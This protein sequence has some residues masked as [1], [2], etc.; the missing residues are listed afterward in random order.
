M[1][2]APGAPHVAQGE[3]R[4]SQCITLKLWTVHRKYSFQHSM[5]KKEGY[6]NQFYEMIPSHRR[7][8]NRPANKLTLM[9]HYVIL[10]FYPE[11]VLVPSHWIKLDLCDKSIPAERLRGKMATTYIAMFSALSKKLQLAIPHSVMIVVGTLP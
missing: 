1:L 4:T 2:I 7:L 11:L 3:W 5:M 10:G 9:S 8:R 6:R